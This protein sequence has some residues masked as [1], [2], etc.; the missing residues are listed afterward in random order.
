MSEI[1]NKKKIAVNTLLLYIRMFFTLVVS[2][3]SSR[4]CLDI[5]GVVDYGIYNVVGGFVSFFAIISASMT[6]AT[7]R[8]LSIELGRTGSTDRDLKHVFSQCF[9]IHVIISLIIIIL[10]ETIGLY[11]VN[12]G[13]NI[14]A[15][16]MDAARIV[17]HFSIIA[18]I[19]NILRSPYEACM[20]AR[21]DMK[22]YAYL[23]IAEVVLKLL[24]IYALIY[25]TSYDS[26]GVYAAMILLTSIILIIVSIFYCN[27]KY[28]E[29][30]LVFVWDINLIKQVG[31]YFG[32]NTV[33][34]FGDIARVEGVNIILNIFFGPAVN[35]ARGI[36]V[37]VQNAVLK[38]VNGF[39]TSVHPELVKSWSAYQVQGMMQL[40]TKSAKYALY[41]YLFLSAPI[42]FNI[43]Y[44]LDLWLKDV[45]EYT[46]VFCILIMIQSMVECINRPLWV[47]I[48]AIGKLRVT[49]LFI[50][51]LYVI[52]II[53][54]YLTLYVGGSPASSFVI[55]ILFMMLVYFVL[56]LRINY[57]VPG[58]LN[59]ILKHTFVQPL[60]VCLMLVLCT[61]SISMP[62]DSF[63]HVVY[64]TILVMI[65]GICIMY[66]VGIDKDERKFISKYMKNK[67]K[68]DNID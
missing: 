39:Q 45:P 16:R 62:D 67:L 6:G 31:A 19:F 17:Y 52:N 4:V 54:V 47:V 38:F 23:G 61:C 27:K 57:L 55:C 60:I 9:I 1:V 59:N 3:Y 26:L 8:F 53:T 29:S 13:L 33:I 63:N 28:Y 35:A 5:L 44:V 11:F 15:E 12:K 43:D 49:H 41:M 46:N 25:I 65:I 34:A 20:I 30:K 37:Q 36:A 40:M 48:G 18:F 10:S 7:Q 64:N 22:F 21:E 50:P 14:P 24:S 42:I 58:Y 51:L 32:W 56:V 2:I 68:R 66:I